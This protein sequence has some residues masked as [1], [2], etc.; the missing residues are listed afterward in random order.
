MSFA[1]VTDLQ[2]KSGPLS[3]SEDTKS[4]KGKKSKDPGN[5]IFAKA[6][7]QFV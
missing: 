3:E 1:K 2:G 5:N 4:K 7:R 6:R